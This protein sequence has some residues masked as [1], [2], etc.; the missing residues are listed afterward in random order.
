MNGS[1]IPEPSQM[2]HFLHKFLEN[3][4]CTFCLCCHTS[5]E[6][7]FWQYLLRHGRMIIYHQISD[8]LPFGISACVLC[9]VQS[10]QA[11][12]PKSCK[13]HALQTFNLSVN[14]Q[15]R[16]TLHTLQNSRNQIYTQH[17]LRTCI[18]IIS[19]PSLHIGKRFAPTSLGKWC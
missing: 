1:R 8:L 5:I 3:V 10:T 2:E 11:L 6:P 4:S 9:S 14:I 12:I 18:F 7:A 19:I 15:Q 17:D 16:H 13:F